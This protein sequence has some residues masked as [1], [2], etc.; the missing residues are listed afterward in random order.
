M[1]ISCFEQYENKFESGIHMRTTESIRQSDV[2]FASTPSSSTT[3]FELEP[4]FW[5]IQ[6]L[7]HMPVG[8]LSHRSRLVLTT[9]S[10]VFTIDETILIKSCCWWFWKQC[11]VLFLSFRR[12]TNVIIELF[13]DCDTSLVPIKLRQSMELWHECVHVVVALSHVS[14]YTFSGL[15]TNWLFC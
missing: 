11:D 14:G 5:N 7:R 6:R 8:F 3:M 12:P 1:K 2:R 13:L 9:L 15:M 4:I 10:F